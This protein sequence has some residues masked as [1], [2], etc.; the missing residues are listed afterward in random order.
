LAR[1]ALHVG[2]VKLLT[3]D[4]QNFAVHFDDADAT[5][6]VVEA[7]ENSVLEVVR[8]AYGSPKRI[9][10]VAERVHPF[11]RD[12]DIYRAAEDLPHSFGSGDLFA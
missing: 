7:F 3:R 6:A 1:V 8:S 10:K 11:D 4:L 9:F 5:V 2:E 12:R